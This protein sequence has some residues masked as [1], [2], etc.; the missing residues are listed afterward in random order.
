VDEQELI[1]SRLLC[2]DGSGLL[3]PLFS[4]SG[5][6]LECRFGKNAA[7]TLQLTFQSGKH[8]LDQFSWQVTRG[9]N[10]F[11]QNVRE[12]N[13]LPALTVVD[14]IRASGWV[15]AKGTGSLNGALHDVYLVGRPRKSSTDVS[16]FAI[17][18]CGA[19]GV[20]VA[21]KHDGVVH[22]GPP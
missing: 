12:W 21:H 3:E 7:G 16:T 1:G 2:F 9:P 18:A 20:H 8:P 10:P 11:N 17:V 22:D 4:A 14:I 5:G 19:G 15:Y 6:Q 13:A